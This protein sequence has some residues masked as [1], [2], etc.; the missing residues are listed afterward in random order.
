M[1]NEVSFRAKKKQAIK[2]EKDLAETKPILQSEISQSEKP[3]YHM[4]PT[5]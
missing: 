1:D 3:I 2:P 4:V 5:K